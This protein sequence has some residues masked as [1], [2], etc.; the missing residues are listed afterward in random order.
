MNTIIDQDK[1]NS[2]PSKTWPFLVYWMIILPILV[3]LEY[4]NPIGIDLK[5]VVYLVGGCCIAYMGGEYVNDFIKNK[6]M[7]AGIGNI[8]NIERHKLLVSIWI[9]YSALALAASYIFKVDLKVTNDI[10]T[11]AAS[12]TVAYVSG[13]KANKSAVTVGP[14]KSISTT[15]SH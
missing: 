1:V 5:L 4:L 7:D 3:A 10:L 9:L 8:E 11:F 2:S 15:D 13:N 12:L 6:S 14:T